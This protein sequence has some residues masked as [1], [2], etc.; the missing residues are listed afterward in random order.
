MKRGVKVPGSPGCC[1][2]GCCRSLGPLLCPLVGGPGAWCRCLVLLSGLVVWA[3]FWS[4]SRDLFLPLFF[5][6]EAFAQ[7]TDPRTGFF[8][9]YSL[10]QPGQLRFT[11]LWELWMLQFLIFFLFSVCSDRCRIIQTLRRPL[12]RLLRQR[13]FP[14]DKV[15]NGPSVTPESDARAEEVPVETGVGYFLRMKALFCSSVDGNELEALGEDLDS[16]WAGA[17]SSSCA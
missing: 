1:R 4:C 14:F 8:D 10:L 17:I 5:G 2:S 13:P 12:N 3:G 6:K 16:T 7:G 11:W 9:R 15:F